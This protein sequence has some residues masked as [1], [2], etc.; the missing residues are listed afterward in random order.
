MQ[1][2]LKINKNFQGILK[3]LYSRIRYNFQ[4]LGIPNANANM[5]YDFM[6]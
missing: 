3:S 1:F 6:G 2:K 5:F 4:N